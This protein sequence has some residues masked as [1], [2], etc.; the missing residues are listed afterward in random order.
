MSSASGLKNAPGGTALFKIA[1]GGAA[2]LLVA[3]CASRSTVSG[4]ASGSASSSPAASSAPASSGSPAQGSASAGADARLTARH[5]YGNPSVGELILEP[6]LA[7]DEPTVSQAAAR[8][9]V[10]HPVVSP[11][12]TGKVL[13]FGL[14]RVTNAGGSLST[15]GS[16][17]IPAFD[18]RLAWVGV[19]ELA[20]NASV[21]CP[22]SRQSPSSLPALLPH[23]YF[24]VLIDAKTG[25]FVTWDEDES[26]LTIRKCAG[27]PVT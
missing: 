18:S 21:M 1:L 19:Y 20:R 16:G 22:G 4:S 10:D 6:P 27:L 7:T 17:P 23:Y 9:Q 5:V 26:G 11:K 3:A 15:S 12:T 13:L 2:V 14:A 8:E 24:V 25:Q